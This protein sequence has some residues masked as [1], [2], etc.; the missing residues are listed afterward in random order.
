M[1]LNNA[2]EVLIC[3]GYEKWKWRIRGARNPRFPPN[4]VFHLLWDQDAGEEIHEL[5]GESIFIS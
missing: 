3:T 1:L 5:K 2:A 4:D